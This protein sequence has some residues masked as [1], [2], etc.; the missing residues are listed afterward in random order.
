MAKLFVANTTVQFRDFMALLPENNRMLRQKIRP[1]QQM[2][3]FDGTMGEIEQ[4]IQQNE[5]YGLT[6]EEDVKRAK[7]FV[8]MIYQIDKPI[9]KSSL[10]IA[11]EG[12]HNALIEFGTET[13][14]NVANYAQASIAN[15][16]R[17]AG[18]ESKS[19]EIEIKDMAKD[20]VFHEV[21]SSDRP[22]NAPEAKARTRRKRS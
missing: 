9:G 11:G 17:Q 7:G 1:G 8:G 12:N 6:R 4:I 22:K 15:M 16:M 5:I 21:F 3:V 13:R 20:P 2:V 10:G 14:E 19:M 18:E